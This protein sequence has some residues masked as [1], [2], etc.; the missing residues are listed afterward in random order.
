VDFTGRTVDHYAIG[1]LIMRGGQGRVYHARDQ[2][3]QRDVAIKVLNADR[4]AG[5]TIHT[6][7]AEARALSR[8]NHPNI[9]GI[10]DFVT[11]HESE[12]LVMEFV[13]GA[14]LQDLLARGPL[15][16]A[17]VLRF[18]T[19]LAQGLAA[20]HSEH[21][22]HCDIK[23]ANLKL[24]RAGVLKIVDFGVA[25]RFSNDVTDDSPTPC[26]GV[27]GTLRYMAPEVLRGLA[28][29]PQSDIFS[30]GAVL[31]EMATGA[32]AFPQTS[33]SGLVE[34]I[35][36][37]KVIAPSTLNSAIPLSLEAVIVRALER[38]PKA[39]YRTASELAEA[40]AG[41]VAPCQA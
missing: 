39:R 15:P 37:S 9:A 20:A 16:V 4:M 7:V 12:F 23:P 13:A 1:D 8:L 31:Y 28:P 2:V 3:L 6:L 36:A 41:I 11:D 22:A 30:A 17:D 14:S 38:R 26:S 32:R 5:L 24:T 33:L 40:L 18:G 34:A 27:A 25:T 19:H 21:I 10:Y 35:D 29:D